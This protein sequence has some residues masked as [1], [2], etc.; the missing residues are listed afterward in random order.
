MSELK[1]LHSIPLKNKLGEGIIWHGASQSV[2]WTD[3]HG[4]FLYQLFCFI[5]PT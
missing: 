4:R 5:K 1:L 3:I 2:W